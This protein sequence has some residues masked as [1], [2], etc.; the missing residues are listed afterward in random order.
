MIQSGSAKFTASFTLNP[1]FRPEWYALGNVT[2]NS[3]GRWW[4]AYMR[5]PS[6]SASAGLIIV[7]SC[8]RSAGSAAKSSGAMRCIAASK[9]SAS[10]PG[11]PYHVLVA[12]MC[13]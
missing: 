6:R 2:T 1:W 5:T 3:F 7:T 10:A 12:P 4:Q 8:S 9:A 13:W 11:T